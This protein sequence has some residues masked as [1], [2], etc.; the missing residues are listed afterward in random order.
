MREF[1]VGPERAKLFINTYKEGVLSALGHDLLIEIRDFQIRIKER[2]NSPQEWD[3]EL[4]AKKESFWPIEPPE[5]SEKDRREINKNIIKHLPDDVTFQGKLFKTGESFRIKGD[6]SLGPRYR[7]AVEFPVNL[8][9]KTAKGEVKLY[10]K[11]LGIKPFKAP[12]GMIKVKDEM[13]FSYQI[14]LEGIIEHLEGN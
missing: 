12:L 6:I 10:H 3:V 1:T 4:L 5:L 14:N 13:K 7:G 8:D 11:Y 9:G 2:E